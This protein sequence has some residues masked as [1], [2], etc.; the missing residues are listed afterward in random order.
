LLL[1]ALCHD[2]K[3]P[4]YNNIYQ[5]NAVTDLAIQFN[6]KFIILISNFNEFQMYLF[7]KIII[8]ENPLD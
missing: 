4:G 8:Q 1:A 3:H 7:L 5:V 6:G 2:F